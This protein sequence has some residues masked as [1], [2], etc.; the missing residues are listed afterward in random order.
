MERLE[1]GTILK[2]K[3]SP[4]RPKV[5]GSARW[6]LLVLQAGATPSPSSEVPE[7]IKF[8][9]KGGWK[10]IFSL[11]LRSLWLQFAANSLRGLLRNL[12]FP[13]RG[14]ENYKENADG[15][16]GDFPGSQ[17]CPL[18][19]L[20]MVSLWFISLDLLRSSQAARSLA[21]QLADSDPELPKLPQRPWSPGSGRRSA[22]W[23]GAVRLEVES[24]E[25]RFSGT[26]Q[27]DVA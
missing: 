20:P 19:Y 17:W 12:N 2:K 18:V 26:K 23:R 13:L 21:L 3:E 24:R 5:L 10:H 14:T 11:C 27:P 25:P 22:T 1:S 15:F 6:D 8:K 16:S 4:P 9:V 7:A